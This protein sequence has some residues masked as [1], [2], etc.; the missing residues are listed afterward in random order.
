M[1][2]DLISIHVATIR[3]PSITKPSITCIFTLVY[4]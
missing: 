4:Q 1:F 2:V 3:Q